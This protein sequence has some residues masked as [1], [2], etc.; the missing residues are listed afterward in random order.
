MITIMDIAELWPDYLYPSWIF[1]FGQLELTQCILPP[2]MAL[3]TLVA[4]LNSRK[5]Q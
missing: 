4:K 2:A 5:L 3:H 1:I